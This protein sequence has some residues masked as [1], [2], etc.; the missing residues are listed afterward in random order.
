MSRQLMFGKNLWM[1]KQFVNEIY[2][3]IKMIFLK[4]LSNLSFF[5][6]HLNPLQK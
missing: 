4:Y 1:K 3:K 5:Q 2:V 6:I